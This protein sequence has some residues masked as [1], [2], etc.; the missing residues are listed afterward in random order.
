MVENTGET[1]R[2]GTCQPVN[3]PEP[4]LVEEDT[5]GFPLA[6]RDKRRYAI[7]A[8]DDRWRLDDEWWRSTPVSRLYYAVRL[9]SGHRLV[10]YKDLTDNCWYRQVY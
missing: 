8:I 9:T 6:I 4:V 1:I 2:T 7:A 10:L 3:T 5:D